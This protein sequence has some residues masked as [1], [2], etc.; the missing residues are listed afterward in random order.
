MSLSLSNRSL[1]TALLPLL[2][3]G[4]AETDPPA[5]LGGPVLVEVSEELG[6]RFSQNPGAHPDYPLPVSMGGG[7]ALFDADSDGDLDL[8]LVNGHSGQDGPIGS[9]G[10]EANALFLQD[11]S[12]R[13]VDATAGSGLGDRGYGMGVAVG[14]ADAD[15]DPDLYVTNLGADRLFLN[16]GSASFT[17]AT[18]AAGLGDTGWGC[19]ATF[20]DYDSDGDLDLFVTRYVE[21]RGSDR[22]TECKDSLGRRDFCSPKTFPSSSDLLYQNQGGARF[23]D[24]SEE[25]GISKESAAG[26]GV[27]AAD[28]DADGLL[29]IYVANDGYANHLWRNRGDGSFTEDAIQRGCALNRDG[30][31]E[32]GMGVLA[33]DL[34]GDGTMDLFMTHLRNESNTLYK[35]LGGGHFTD[36]T[37]RVGIARPSLPATGFGTTA[38]DIELDG[39]LDIVVVNGRVTRTDAAPGA[40]LPAPWDV[41]CEANMILMGEGASYTPAQATGDFD[42]DVSVSRGL[43]RG[44]IDADG[45]L[46]L[47]VTGVAGPVKLYRNDTPRA[48]AW[49]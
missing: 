26:L 29:D 24:V 44:D 5:D 46:D 7:V 40:A 33:E 32:A 36:A 8:Y 11:D 37:A 31:P 10:E 30:A 19:S 4:C 35:N 20:L 3:P 47:V 21:F 23:L 15:G 12:G 45:D 13:F 17:D 49:L 48:G 9:T 41:Y 39:D 42:A 25:S 16:A 27:V 22:A 38:L 6:L 14:D 28:F 18:E 34:D 43:A 1:L 2:L